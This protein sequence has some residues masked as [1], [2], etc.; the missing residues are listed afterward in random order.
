MLSCQYNG[1]DMKIAF[2]AKLM[3]EMINNMDGDE[4]Q[5]EL[6]TPTRAGIFRPMEKGDNEDVLMLLMPL[7]VGV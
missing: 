5:V 6:S 2:N 1:E 4:M 7:M 3:V